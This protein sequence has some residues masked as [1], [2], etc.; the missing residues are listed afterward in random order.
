MRIS[1]QSGAITGS[2][3]FRLVWRGWFVG[4]IAIFLPTFLL[5]G[6]T[7]VVPGYHSELRPAEYFLGLLVL[8]FIA[9]GQALIVGALVSLG[10]KIRPPRE[11][12]TTKSSNNSLE[13]DAGNSRASG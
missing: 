11:L 4:V 10:L 2:E 13:G 1:V 7:I 12:P 6:F 3:L 5:F 9:A 8:P